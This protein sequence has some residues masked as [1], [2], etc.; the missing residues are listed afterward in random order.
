MPH[1]LTVAGWIDTT[2][3]VSMIQ[4]NQVRFDLLQSLSTRFHHFYIMPE[5]HSLQVYYQLST[6]NKETG[7]RNSYHTVTA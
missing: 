1:R 5:Q 6:Q 7:L 3:Q 2:L 4:I